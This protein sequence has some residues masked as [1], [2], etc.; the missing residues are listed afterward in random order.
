LPNAS[1]NYG[2][3]NKQLP[4]YPIYNLANSFISHFTY[5]QFRLI[6]SI[7]NFSIHRGAFVSAEVNEI[8]DPMSVNASWD[9][10]ILFNATMHFRKGAVKNPQD[11]YNVLVRYALERNGHQLGKSGLYLSPYQQN[12]FSACFKA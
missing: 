4:N 12:P 10:G 7:K 1:P 5:Q 9:S 6:F 3:K 8:L 11:A 2:S